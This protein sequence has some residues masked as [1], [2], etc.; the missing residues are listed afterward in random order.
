MIKGLLFIHQNIYTW[1]LFSA[2][3][4]TL[5]MNMNKKLIKII[6]RCATHMK[7]LSIKI[8]NKTTINR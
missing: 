6:L 4:F 1:M 8:R 2:D 7:F 5:F 3:K